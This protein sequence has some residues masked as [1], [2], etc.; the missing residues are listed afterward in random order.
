MFVFVHYAYTTCKRRRIPEETYLFPSGS[1]VV[2]FVLC[3]VILRTH[4]H[5]HVLSKTHVNT[6]PLC[7]F[8]SPGMHQRPCKRKEH[9]SSVRNYLVARALW[10]RF[11]FLL[12]VQLPTFSL[13]FSNSRQLLRH[14]PL[15]HPPSFVLL[16]LVFT[17]SWLFKLA[18][19]SYRL[20]CPLVRNLPT[21]RTSI[22]KMQCHKDQWCECHVLPVSCYVIIPR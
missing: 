9:V 21:E 4:M 2:A 22:V 3:V 11:F 17:P 6:N 15:H 16:P 7:C 18:R 20:W 8:P 19:C 10:S 14:S 12:I 5:I 13:H 1:S